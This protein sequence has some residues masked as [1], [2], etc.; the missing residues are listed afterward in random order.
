MVI[1]GF[2][3]MYVYG[4]YDAEKLYDRG[5]KFGHIVGGDAYNY[6]IIGIRGVGWIIAGFIAAMMATAIVI[7]DVIREVVHSTNSASDRSWRVSRDMVEKLDQ[8]TV[9]K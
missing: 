4:D 2:I 8:V 7:V 5:S 3:T 1:F 9:E 6:I